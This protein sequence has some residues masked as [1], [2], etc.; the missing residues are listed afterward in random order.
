MMPWWSWALIWA[1]LVAALIALLTVSGL[2]LFHKA[3][4][5]LD[6]LGELA[7]G[8][9]LLDRRAQRMSQAA[10]SISVFDGTAGPADRW[11]RLRRARQ[12]HR[13][14]RREERVAQGRIL[15]TAD[16][17]RYAHLLKRT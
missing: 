8:I 16:Y 14:A 3:M 11:S 12:V 2:R 1:A 9:E 5:L 6:A 15:I 17:R 13:Q 10:V 7:D 4:A